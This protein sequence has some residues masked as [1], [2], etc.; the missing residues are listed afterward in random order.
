MD[1]QKPTESPCDAE[2]IAMLGMFYEDLALALLGGARDEE[3]KD[4]CGD[5]RLDDLDAFVEVKGGSN[6]NSMAL[7]IDQLM[8][9]R[10]L[11]PF[12]FEHCWYFLANYQNHATQA[13]RVRSAKVTYFKPKLLGHR[14]SSAQS[15]ATFLKKSTDLVC[16]IDSAILE[17]MTTFDRFCHTQ[18]RWYDETQVIRIGRRY[19]QD[20]ATNGALKE[21][22]FSQDEFVVRDLQVRPCAPYEIMTFR[23][24]LILP[25]LQLDL[26]EASLRQHC[27]IE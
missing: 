16:L 2:R 7:F 9:W 22:G 13:N 25:P 17:R 19:I 5:I 10:K 6:R 15:L 20:L 21:L 24:I 14:S 8:R 23:M 18:R 3:S 12:P 11:T 4:R 26:V 1:T 27:T